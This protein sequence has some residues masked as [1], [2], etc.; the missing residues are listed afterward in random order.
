MA[1]VSNRNF[2]HENRVIISQRFSY[3]SSKNFTKFRYNFALMRKSY[4]AQIMKKILVLA[5]LAIPA[6]SLF[7]AISL[8]LEKQLQEMGWG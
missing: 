4:F 1:R 5:H 7:R 6:V 8:N 2:L 3:V